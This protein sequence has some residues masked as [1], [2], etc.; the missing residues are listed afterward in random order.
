MKKIWSFLLALTLCASL[1]VPAWADEVTDLPR[2]SEQIGGKAD[3]SA[4]PALSAE[5]VTDPA[6]QVPAGFSDVPS[7]H[8]FYQGVMDC[9]AKGIVG[10]YD[11]GT[12]RPGNTVTKSNFSVM[13]S[14]AFYAGDIDKHNDSYNL[15][16]YGPFAG[17]YLA[18][19]YDGVYEGASF[20][21][22]FTMMNLETMNTGINR[23]DMAQLM[24][25]IMKQRGLAASDSEKNAAVSE[26][27]DYSEIPGQYKDAVLN[28]YAL[29]IIG[30]YAN[31]TFGGNVTMNRGQAAVVIY[32]M[33]QKLGSAPSTAPVEPAPEAPATPTEPEQPETPVDPKP[34]TPVDPGPAPSGRTLSNGKAITEANVTEILENLKSRYPKG[35][36]FGNGYA[37]MN[38]GRSGAN[39]CIKQITNQ[40]ECDDGG[41][42]STTFGCGGWAAFVCD[43]IFS[44]T[45]VTWRKT[46]LSDIRPGD[47]MIKL[48]EN[49]HLMHVQVYTGPNGTWLPTQKVM[50]TDAGSQ[51]GLSKDYTV[52]W[53]SCVMTRYAYDIWTA[54]PD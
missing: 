25:N 37:G 43:E 31:G 38:S 1:A 22:D 4:A 8:P 41:K 18:L 9:A 45:N 10:G 5:S 13:L 16:T 52:G 51:T 17:N 49:G 28:V 36:Y 33:V 3:S 46:N 34:E 7:G 40:Y 54:Y 53:G 39:N 47:L 32:R 14:R 50:V 6:P 2:T 24:T 48:D 12:F 42:V 35:T 21:S 15:Y 20:K 30:G 19:Y 11:D 26:I 27:T 23:Y 44:Q 29:G